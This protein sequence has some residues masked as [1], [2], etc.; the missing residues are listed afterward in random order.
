[1]ARPATGRHILTYDQREALGIE[2]EAR[3]AAE[4]RVRELEEQLRGQGGQT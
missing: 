2:R 1:M 4:A 3:Y